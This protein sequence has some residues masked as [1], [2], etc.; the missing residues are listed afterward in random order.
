[1]MDASKELLEMKEHQ[2]KHQATIE[3]RNILR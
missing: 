3:I 2:I 1:M